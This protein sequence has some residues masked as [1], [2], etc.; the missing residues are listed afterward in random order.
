[1]KIKRISA[2]SCKTFIKCEFAYFLNYEAGIRQTSNEKMAIGNVVHF[3]LEMWGKAHQGNKEGTKDY[4]K[5]LRK[6]YRER[7][8]DA[9]TEGYEESVKVCSHCPFFENGSCNVL[10]EKI[11]D[12]EGC[13]KMPFEKCIKLTED[14]LERESNPLEI[15]KILGVEQEFNMKFGDCPSVGYIDLISEMNEEV[16]EIRDWKTGSYIQTYAQVRDDLQAKIYDIAVKELYPDHNGIIVTLDY[17]QGKPVSV[18]YSEEEREKN[19]KE[20]KELI[21]KIRNVK[22]PRRRRNDWMCKSMCIGRDNCDVYWKKFKECN[23]DVEKYNK[24]EEDN[25][26]KEDKNGK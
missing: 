11:E 15:Y 18:A 12:F 13:P 17:I 9:L 6:E 4:K 1:M 7:R 25:N 5:S 26:R 2:S 20:I 23:F 8:P 24:I 22:T 10:D 14:V 3:A 21:Q 19:K 16:I